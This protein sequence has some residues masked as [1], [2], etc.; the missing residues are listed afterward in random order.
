MQILEMAQIILADA[1]RGS[2]GA[3]IGKLEL[4]EH[5][6]EGTSSY[7]HDDIVRAAFE[8]GEHGRA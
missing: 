5:I 3:T 7:M 1:K 6:L 2:A 4:V 8:E